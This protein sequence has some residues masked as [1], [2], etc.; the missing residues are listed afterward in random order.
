MVDLPII[1]CENFDTRGKCSFPGCT[2][3][4]KGIRELSEKPDKNMNLPDPM[5]LFEKPVVGRFIGY[6]DVMRMA[7]S[8]TGISNPDEPGFLMHVS[9]GR[10]T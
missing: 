4:K 10:G 7:F 3:S 6:Q 8:H 5:R 9:D 2:F 1:I